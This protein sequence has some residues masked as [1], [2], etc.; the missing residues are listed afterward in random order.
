[1]ER[2]YI[3]LLAI[4]TSEERRVS[5][6]EI[7]GRKSELRLLRNLTCSGDVTLGR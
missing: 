6:C 2:R 4:V 5:R 7:F 3:L 1:M